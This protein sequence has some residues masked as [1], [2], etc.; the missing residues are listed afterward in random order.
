GGVARGAGR[1]RELLLA[2]RPADPGRA[3]AAPGAAAPDRPAG[4]RARPHSLRFAAR[5]LYSHGVTADRIR[6]VVLY[7]GAAA[8]LAAGAL[9]WDRAAPRQPADS[10]MAQWTATAERLLPEPEDAEAGETLQLKAGTE[11]EISANVEDGPH[12][13]T[14]VCVGG[15]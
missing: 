4:L 6:G 15:R 5:D 3:A 2:D 9:W 10:S 7:A 1:V 11:R 13:I 14:V 12:H 8:L